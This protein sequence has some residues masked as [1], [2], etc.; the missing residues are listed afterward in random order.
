LRSHCVVSVLD[1][2]LHEDGN[3]TGARLRMAFARSFVHH[4]AA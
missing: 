2:K 4:A 1:E 3:C